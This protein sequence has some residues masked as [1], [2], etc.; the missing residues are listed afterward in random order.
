MEQRRTDEEKIVDV[1]SVHTSPLPELA[2]GDGKPLPFAARASSAAPTRA[3]ESRTHFD[4]LS[5]GCRVFE[6]CKLQ[7]EDGPSREKRLEGMRMV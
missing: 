2:K 6:T 4:Y 7:G 3:K 1:S 5:L